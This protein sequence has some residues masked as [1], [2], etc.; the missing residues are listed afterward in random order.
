MFERSDSNDLFSL[1]PDGTDFR[2]L[3]TIPRG[4]NGEFTLL[5]M[6]GMVGTQVIYAALSSQFVP[7]LF[8][9]PV[10]GGVVTT[11]ASSPDNEFLGDVVGSRVVYHR[12]AILPNFE[13]GQCDLYSVQSDGSATVALSTNP[14]NEFV[15]EIVGTRIV[16]TRSVGGQTDIYSGNVDGSGTV[17][18]ATHP[19][20]ETVAG[21][22][23]S[24]VIFRRT[25]GGLDDLYSIQADST[26]GEIALATF[27]EEDS[28]AGVV[29]TRVIFE[30]V[31]GPSIMSSPRQ[32]YSVQADGSGLVPLT[33]GTERDEFA[34]AAGDFACFERSQGDQRDLWCVPADGRTPAAPIATTGADEYFVTSF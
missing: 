19:Q 17:P 25:I 20:P 31:M 12:C 26:G 7:D 13:A 30:R 21:V 24:R 32:L 5:G 11:L 34:G 4:P 23:G 1:L 10:T 15:A 2:Q 33:P 28:F 22:V 27:P 29:G 8:A 6:R 3:T 14:G 16:Y 9:V 18:L